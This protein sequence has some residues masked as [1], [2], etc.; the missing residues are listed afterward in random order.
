[1]QSRTISEQSESIKVQSQSISEQ[2]ERTKV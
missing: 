1:V 2:S